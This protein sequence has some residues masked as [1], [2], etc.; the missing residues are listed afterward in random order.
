MPCPSTRSSQPF[1]ALLVDFDGHVIGLNPGRPFE[2]VD[3]GLCS[4]VVHIFRRLGSLL[5]QGALETVVVDALDGALVLLPLRPHKLVAAFVV[6]AHVG[7]ATV[8]GLKG[9]LC[10]LL[11][12][13]PPPTGEPVS[14]L[15]L[16]AG[17]RQEAIEVL[18]SSLAQLGCSNDVLDDDFRRRSV[19]SLV[20]Q[21]CAGATT[22]AAQQCLTSLCRLA[23]IAGVEEL[24]GTGT[25]GSAYGLDDGTVLKLTRDAHEAHATAA[26]VGCQLRRFPTVLRVIRW[27]VLGRPTGCFG[28]VREA[29]DDA[30]HLTGIAGGAARTA[31][32]LL[33]AMRSEPAGEA[34]GRMAALGLPGWEL[35]L[36]FAREIDAELRA[37]GILFGDY[38]R[39]NVGLLRGRLCFFD[40]SLARGP[41]VELEDIDLAS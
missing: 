26:L 9:R 29:V 11:P 39:Q 35:A 6:P 20:H 34:Q 12:A 13:G 1:A 40:L 25:F 32:E 31:C 24:L 23:D 41:A 3:A 15:R 7:M 8:R 28:I 10:E 21:C 2:M 5:E 27:V 19:T 36:P 30:G 38:Q 16:S 37:K 18:T 17:Q 22:D 14:V 33:S 4:T